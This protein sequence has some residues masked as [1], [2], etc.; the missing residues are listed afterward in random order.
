MKADQGYRISFPFLYVQTRKPIEFP[1]KKLPLTSLVLIPPIGF[2]IFLPIQSGQ[3]K[4]NLI[5]P[6]NPVKSRS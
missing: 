6:G 3:L 2:H 4:G 1:Q 5:S